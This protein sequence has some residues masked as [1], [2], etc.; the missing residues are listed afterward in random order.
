MSSTLR[1]SNALN[2]GMTLSTFRLCLSISIKA[3]KTTALLLSLQVKLISHW[4]SHWDSMLSE[5]R[6]FC[7]L[8]LAYF[9]HYKDTLYIL[10]T[11]K[12]F[13]IPWTTSPLSQWI[14]NLSIQT[15]Q[16]ATFWLLSWHT[17]KV[18]P[19]T[20]LL[21]MDSNI[22]YIMFYLLTYQK[23]GSSIIPSTILSYSKLKFSEVSSLISS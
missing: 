10:C 15:N 7:K 20:L 3:I 9:Y 23:I 16:K 18:Y 13:F 22:Y 5:T 2:W 1:Q 11:S 17:F 6:D 4:D 12:F 8:I 19:F 21:P 14:V